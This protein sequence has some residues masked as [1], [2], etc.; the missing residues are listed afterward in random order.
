MS[1]VLAYYVATAEHLIGSLNR[2][3]TVVTT[4]A[5]L[6]IIIRLTGKSEISISDVATVNVDWIALAL[7]A[8]TLLHWW[9][10][11]RAARSLVEVREGELSVA[12]EDSSFLL[13]RIPALGWYTNGALPRELSPTGRIVF[14]WTDPSIQVAVVSLA[15]G[16][17]AL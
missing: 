2:L 11:G 5:S 13:D 10:A 16:I 14:R 8:L 12:P 4:A 7:P 6:V 17:A 1:R 15:M 3:L 9:L